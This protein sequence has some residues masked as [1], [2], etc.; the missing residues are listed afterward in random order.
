[1]LLLQNIWSQDVSKIAQSGHTESIAQWLMYG[2]VLHHNVWHCISPQ[3]MAL[4]CTI[5]DGTVLHYNAWRCIAPKCV[6]LQ[7]STTMHDRS[8]N[9]LE[10]LR[11]IARMQTLLMHSC[12]KLSSRYSGLQQKKCFILFISG[13]RHGLAHG[14]EDRLVHWEGHSGIAAGEILPSVICYLSI[15]CRNNV[16]WPYCSCDIK[17]K[18]Y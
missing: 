12:H 11:S 4:Y 13:C 8:L 14:S 18:K 3:C 7:C 6:A 15:A 17:I 2:T 10:I 5:M 9:E 16:T 1:M